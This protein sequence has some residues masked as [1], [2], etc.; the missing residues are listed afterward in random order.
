MQ[1]HLVPNWTTSVRETYEFRTIIFTSE[2]GKEQRSADRMTPRRQISFSPQ[3]Y[4]PALR[5]FKNLMHDRGAAEITIADPARYGISLLEDAEAGAEEITVAPVPPWIEDGIQIALSTFFTAEQIGLEAVAAVSSFS[6]AYSSDFGGGRAVITLATPLQSTWPAGTEVRPVV[7]GRLPQ[8]VDATFLT[9]QHAEVSVTFAVDPPSNVPLLAAG[10]EYSLFQGRPVLLAKPNWV[11]AASIQFDTAYEQVDYQRGI[12]ANYLPIEYAARISQF[13]YMDVASADI[14]SLLA[15]FVDMKG[16][17]GEFWSPSWITDFIPASQVTSGATTFVVRG[18]DT[19]HSYADST[20]NNAIAIMKG[21][22]S[23]IFAEVEEMSLV[24]SASGGAFS[25]GYSDGFDAPLADQFT[26]I[27]VSSP[28]EETVAR[29]DIA[30]VCWLNLCRFASDTLTLD[31]RSDNLAQCLANIM[32][33]ETNA[34][35]EM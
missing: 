19:Y 7:R 9:D 29:K 3:L 30:M 15:L 33:L 11:N 34:V 8:S 13:N 25:S 23:W 20:V 31:W 17:R 27:T 21:D 18:I 28:F 4:G 32:T 24:S 10:L 6:S 26:Q 5:Q 14:A 2:N 35:E 1:A 22:G 12:I 16:R